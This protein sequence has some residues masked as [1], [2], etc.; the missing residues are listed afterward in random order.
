[1]GNSGIKD[2]YKQGF[3]EPCELE[4]TPDAINTKDKTGE[5]KIN[6]SEIE[7]I[8]EI[9]DHYFFKAR[10]G[11]SLIIPKT[12]VEDLAKIRNEI[13]LLVE[14]NGAKHNIDLDWRWR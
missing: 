1:L 8:N 6:K 10:S 13:A 7:E 4:F 2:T 12:K 5:V 9:K 14:T 11:T 3:G